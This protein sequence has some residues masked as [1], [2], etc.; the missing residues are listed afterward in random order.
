MVGMSRRSLS[1]RIKGHSH[2]REARR[3]SPRLAHH[4]RGEATF[5]SPRLA[6]VCMVPR[7]RAARRR[8]KVIKTVEF[9]LEMHIHSNL[10]YSD[11]LSLASI[12]RA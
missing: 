9:L 4:P 12:T 1:L 11:W 2:I 3:T 6:Y 10:L 5:A 7:V 8:I